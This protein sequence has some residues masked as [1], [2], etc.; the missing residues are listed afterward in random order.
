MPTLKHHT[1]KEQDKH[2]HKPTVKDFIKEMG[3]EQILEQ[4]TALPQVEVDRGTFREEEITYKD[5]ELKISTVP[6][7]KGTRVHCEITTKME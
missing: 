1:L 3:F 7:E 4:E 5:E 6:M 2:R